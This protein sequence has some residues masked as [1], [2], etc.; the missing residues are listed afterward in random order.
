MGLA[1]TRGPYQGESAHLVEVH[2][3]LAVATVHC[4]P[5][6]GALSG[7]APL[8]WGAACLGGWEPAG[9]GRLAALPGV[10]GTLTLA[11]SPSPSRWRTW[12]PS[13]CPVL[14][15]PSGAGGSGAGFPPLPF[16]T[17]RGGMAVAFSCQPCPPPRGAL[18]PSDFPLALRDSARVR[19]LINQCQARHR[20]QGRHSS[21]ALQ[22]HTSHCPGPIQM[23]R[24]QPMQHI[25]EMRQKC[26]GSRE[27]KEEAFSP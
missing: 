2:Q 11:R 16:P 21:A 12:A 13:Q 1:G 27:K 18:G 7:P 15:G 9:K 4:D 25:K 24:K 23:A 17:G 5:F 14:R 3:G 20:Q 10:P 8:R 19:T 22:P 26:K 6:G